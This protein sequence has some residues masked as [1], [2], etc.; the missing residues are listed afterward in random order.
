MGR[1]WGPSQ[2]GGPL[3]GKEV[4]LGDILGENILE[5]VK[6]ALDSEGMGPWVTELRSVTSEEG[7]VRA[8]STPLCAS[9]RAVVMVC[10]SSGSGS[11]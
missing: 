9:L 8:V 4:D 5:P 1:R 7:M 11:A 2:C 6:Q 3:L 10:T